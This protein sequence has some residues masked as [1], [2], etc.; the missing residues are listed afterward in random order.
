M[1]K[2]L[3]IKNA[4]KILPYKYYK[5]ILVVGPK[6]RQISGILKKMSLEFG[7]DY[8]NLNLKLSEK[9]IR[10]PFDERC[11][12][13]EEYVN[14][15]IESY[16]GSLLIFDNTEILFEKHLKIDPLLLMKNLSRYKA[17]I[18]HW[19]GKVEDGHLIYAVPQHP[20]FAKYR[21]DEHDYIV[22]NTVQEK[23]SNI[24]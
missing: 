9:L 4:I 14:E 5:L 21:I 11:F 24:D 7:Y 17:I 16:H 2:E 3:D 23:Q 22:I 10:L 1:L 13:V 12:Y 18:A 8:I 15:I 19:N 6:E 20:D